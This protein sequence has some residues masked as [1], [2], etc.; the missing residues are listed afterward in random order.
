MPPAFSCGR[1][2]TRFTQWE[3][4]P[5]IILQETG[6]VN[7]YLWI[8][9]AP[10]RL[11]KREILMNKALSKSGGKE[12]EAVTMKS[13][14][15]HMLRHGVCEGNAEGR[16]IGR[17][18]SP[19]AMES[20]R[21]LLAFKQQYQYPQASAFYASPSTRCVDTLKILYPEA[22]PEVI[23]EM[24]ECDFG[25][26][27]GKT[28]KELEADPQ[29]QL[30]MESGSKAAPPNGE[31]GMVFMQRV[32]KGFEMLVENLMHQG[33]TEA[34]LVTH[35]GVIMSVLSV[36][37]LPKANFYD[38][39]C[40]PGGGYTLRITPMLWMR[41]MVLEVEETLPKGLNRET[42]ASQLLN[43]ARKAAN[44]AY[45]DRDTQA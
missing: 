29:F 31:S 39:M 6:I 20:I 2:E 37:G 21:E 45:G 25:D 8:F 11:E 16:Y 35:A 44:E 19:L 30:W 22:R 3:K 27:E 1:W 36:Y 43:A 40:E 15:L 12:R 41:G 14:L 33:N 7:L 4:V 34:V 13:Y 23:L 28:A 24:A 5:F 42:P 32:C 17:T 38:W 26:W 18:E 10:L 9:G